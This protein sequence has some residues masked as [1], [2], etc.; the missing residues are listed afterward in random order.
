MII[1]FHVHT[2]PEK[3]SKKVLRKLGIAAHIRYYTEGSEKS[4][5]ES[6]KKAGI[7][8]SVIQT[9]ATNVPQVEKLNHQLVERQEE[10]QAKGLIPF[11]GFHPDYGLLT[12]HSV[13][14]GTPESIASYRQKVSKEMHY[15]KSHGIKGIKL[16]PAY[17]GVAI[18]SPAMMQIIDLASCYDLIT[19]VHAGIDIGIYDKNYASVDQLIHVIDTIHPKKLILAHMGNWGLWDQVESD[20]AGAPVFF[21]TSFSLGKLRPSKDLLQDGSEI[22][23]GITLD[24]QRDHSFDLPST[25]RDIPTKEEYTLT[26]GRLLAPPILKTNLSPEDF[27]RLCRK[28]GTDHILFGTDSPWEDQEEYL[29]WTRQS[30]LNNQEL[31]A[32][33]GENAKKLLDL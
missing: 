17:Q 20:L 29:R 7:D 22:K 6:M 24:D 1:D 3:I 12:E 19:L 4:L 25:P 30:G 23:D 9:V 27:T 33:L 15:L 11:G 5:A 31:T 28:H 2:F 32:I 8:Y 18:D 26:D 21:D 14:R 13:L 10:L 16:H